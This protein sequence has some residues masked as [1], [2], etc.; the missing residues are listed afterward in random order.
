MNW[1]TISI[2]NTNDLINYLLSYESHWLFRG[3]S[4][5]KWILESTLE[6]ALKPIGWDPEWAQNSEEYSLF[7]FKAR[8]HHYIAQESLPS[9]KLGLLSLMQH[10]GVPTRLLDFTESPFVAL[11]FA[12]DGLQSISKDACAIWAIDYRALMKKSIETI[13]STDENFKLTYKEAQMKQDEIFELIDKN[14]YDVL[15]TTE[16][17]KFNLRLE[18]QRGSFLIS[19]NIR[20]RIS[21]LLDTQMPAG[22]FKKIVIPSALTNEIFVAL[23]KMGISNSRL[24]SDIDGL[25]KDV[26]NEINYQINSHFK[27][28]KTS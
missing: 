27:Q 1:E 14:S 20:R 22:T 28:N 21:E 11:F 6:R 13:Q 8:A 25:G 3:H 15:W 19:G 16:P 23:K 10:H 9:S 5:E 24:F 4:S 26:K 18:R 17:G 12:F 2:T 7:E